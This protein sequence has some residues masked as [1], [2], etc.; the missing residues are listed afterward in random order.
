MLNVPAFQCPSQTF[1]LFEYHLLFISV[2][3]LIGQGSGQFQVIGP[4]EPIQALVG[5]DVIF[6]CHVLPKMSL[7]NMEVRFFRN[8][9]SSVLL[10]Y[11][12]GKEEN[13]R[14]MQEYQARTQFVQD[15]ITEGTVSLK[16]KNITPSDMATYGCWFSSKT[17][18]QHY[19]W[20]LQVAAMGS[21]PLI[22][23][24]G[25]R[26]GGILLVCQ[27]AGWLPQPKVQWRQD[28]GQCLS[29]NYTVVQDDHGLFFIETTFTMKEHSNKNIVCSVL[30]FA[31]KREKESRV[32]V[33][34]Q[35]FQTS[36][37]SNAFLLMMFL[38]LAALVF[39]IFDYYNKEK[40]KK[41]LD[42]KKKT[43]E[44]EWMEAT[45]YSV[46]VTLDPDTAHP[47]LRVSEDQK[48]VTYED[49]ELPVL[50][51]EKR[52]EFPCVV[53]SQSFSS[54]QHYWEVEV[55][56]MKRWYLGVCWDGVKRKEREITFSPDN[57]YWVLGVWNEY[58]YFVFDP[59][60]KALTLLVQARRIGVFLSFEARE[61]SFFNVTE[62]SHI[63][64]FTN[65]S[66]HGKALYPYFCPRKSAN[67]E[68]SIP[69]SISPVLTVLYRDISQISSDDVPSPQTTQCLLSGISCHSKRL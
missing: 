20:E 45:E 57:G 19:T 32:Q 22:S 68:H 33:S 59:T 53:A 18:Y 1:H 39:L 41:K 58:E 21:T 47:K 62:K 65:C 69:M 24:E 54:D 67:P 56:E 42:L 10:L 27:S 52:F 4:D 13:E 8:Q 30:N 60:R 61:V 17:F 31:L 28:S 63:Y 26:D 5:E 40:I 7:E 14:Q 49:T 66:F 48:S 11:K 55:G 38:I 29:S 2:L 12:D 23:L 34:D 9:F 3:S 35:F 51:T 50:E 6:S 43:K 64:T 36:P 25:Y 37:W 16:L 15:A 44:A 46:E